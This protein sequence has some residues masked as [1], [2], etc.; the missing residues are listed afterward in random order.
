MARFRGTV[1][2]N[3][4]T[5]SR[6]G[7]TKGGLRVQ[8]RSWNGDVQTLLYDKDGEDWATVIL[9]NGKG[10]SI[11]LYR[12]PLADYRGPLNREEISLTQEPTDGC[13]S[14]E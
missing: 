5:A 12:G 3:R 4:G 7:H 1:V 13:Y 10:S 6:L 11:V 14:A 9:T 8:A 2:G